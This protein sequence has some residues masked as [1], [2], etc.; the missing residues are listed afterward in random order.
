MKKL[1]KLSLI[2][3][4]FMAVLT[5]RS[6]ADDTT[7]VPATDT[8][9]AATP[10]TTSGSY[11]AYFDTSKSYITVPII[12]K[13]L[14]AGK[15]SYIADT[16]KTTPYSNSAHTLIE[17]NGALKT[18]DFEARNLI[19]LNSDVY[20][21]IYDETSLEHPLVADIKAEK[22]NFDQNNY[23]SSE[24]DASYNHSQFVFSLPFVQNS[25]SMKR[26]VHYK[27][28]RI[29]DNSVL[30]AI[31]SNA[32]DGFAKLKEYAKNDA[33]PIYNETQISNSPF[34]YT[35]D[36]QI[37]PGNQFADKGYYYLYAELDTENGKYIP[38][39][40][41][42]LA[43][44]EVHPSLDGYPW[45]LFFYG[46]SNFSLD[47]IPDDSQNG[48]TPSEESAPESNK[49]DDTVAKTN[50]ARTGEKAIIFALIGVAF[51]ASV[52]FFRKNKNTIIK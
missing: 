22:P 4:L 2:V 35:T 28:G 30:R 44:A 20:V 10:T 13:G 7:T 6:Y 47:D 29:S 32:S 43:Q 17:D 12:V 33:N 40:S 51:V 16:N 14:P 38:I 34:G 31:K 39:D 41:V 27:L 24:A 21:H 9:T 25:D 5:I 23:F 48:E 46:K 45:F 42:T 52:V 3:S 15:Y 37:A 8:D 49:V 18:P 26:T 1:L 19:Q 11:S 50:L 36:T